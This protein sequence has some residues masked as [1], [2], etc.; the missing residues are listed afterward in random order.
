[1]DTNVW[2]PLLT[3]RLGWAG[4]TSS[5][6]LRDRR[7]EKRERQAREAERAL[8]REERRDEFQREALLGLQE[9]LAKLGRAA[10]EA[11]LH[12]LREHR[13]TGTPWPDLRLGKELDEELRLAT[14]QVRMLEERVLDDELRNLVQQFLDLYTEALLAR[15]EAEAKAAY[16]ALI[17]SNERAQA[18]LG[19]L[20]RQLY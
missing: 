9:A 17:A 2:L 8:R 13:Q 5:E 14:L 3:L 16:N 4:A 6:F 15:S 19:T 18:R 10:T 11:H 12:D 7:Q 20:L 1:M